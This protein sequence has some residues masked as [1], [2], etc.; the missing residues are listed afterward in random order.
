MV[1]RSNDKVAMDESVIL[2]SLSAAFLGHVPLK[3]SNW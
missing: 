2:W 1:N 3:K